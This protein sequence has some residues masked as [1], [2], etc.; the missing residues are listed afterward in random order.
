MSLFLKHVPWERAANVVV[1]Y[2]LRERPLA[3]TIQAVI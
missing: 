3:A 1:I 2:G